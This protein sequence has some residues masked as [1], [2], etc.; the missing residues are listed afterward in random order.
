[1]IARESNQKAIELYQKLGFSIE[2]KMKN[3]IK[4]LDNSFEA[5]IMMAWFREEN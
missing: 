3:R 4:N 1:L 2:G 5:D